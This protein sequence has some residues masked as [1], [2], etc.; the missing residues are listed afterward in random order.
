MYENYNLKIH[1]SVLTTNEISL[2]CGFDTHSTLDLTGC[3]I[4]SQNVVSYRIPEISIARKQAKYE[5]ES[6]DPA[7]LYDLYSR[8]F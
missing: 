8:C 4:K 6:P 7:D 5:T 1:C 3:F 2:I